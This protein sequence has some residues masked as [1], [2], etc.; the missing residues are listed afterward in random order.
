[1]DGDLVIDRDP[2]FQRLR[3]E[4]ATVFELYVRELAT[5][6]EWIEVAQRAADYYNARATEVA[7]KF[8]KKPVL[9]KPERFK[10]G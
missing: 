6:E 4:A 1:M 8:G 9:I 2:E 3:A 5:R 10:R 7:K